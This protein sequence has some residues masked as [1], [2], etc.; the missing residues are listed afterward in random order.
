[1]VLMQNRR[2]R[3][4]LRLLRDDLDH[5][6][7]EPTALRHLQSGDLEQLCPMASLPHPL[8]DKA[9]SLLGSDPNRD[10]ALEPI[11]CATALGLLELR[12]GQW[13]GAV[14][15][16]PETHVRWLVAGGLAKGEHQDQ[17]DF[18]NRLDRLFRAGRS[19]TLLPTD[20]DRDLLKLETAFDLVH[21]WE[22]DL[23]GDVQRVLTSLAATNGGTYR[24][25]IHHPARA[26]NIATVSIA[27][28]SVEDDDY[29]AEEFVVEVDLRG[30]FRGTDLGWTMITRVLTCVCPP[31]QSWDRYGDTMS[32]IAEPGFARRQASHLA[33]MAKEGQL[34]RSS[35]GDVSHWTHRP[36]LAENTIDGRSVRALCGVFFVPTQ[37]H[38]S[39][40]ICPECD[41]SYRLVLAP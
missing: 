29:L 5:D 2:A 23:Q 13:R 41:S 31:D 20:E 21:K 36:N 19:A 17:D 38:E 18:Y 11:R 12:A 39:L 25:E 10:G 15:T 8:I 9:Q 30:E 4:T 37:D 40:P 1:M 35:P 33:R 32:A 3:P 14:W 34:C 24:M 27:M 16:D 22:M 26:N 7:A 28:T 6:W